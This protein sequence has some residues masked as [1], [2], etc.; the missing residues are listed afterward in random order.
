M[1]D[2]NLSSGVYAGDTLEVRQTAVLR[3]RPKK[4]G[5]SSLTKTIDSSIIKATRSMRTNICKPTSGSP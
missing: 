2:Y 3:R 4:R 1:T 5:Q